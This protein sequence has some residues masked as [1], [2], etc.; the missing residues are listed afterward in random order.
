MRITLY[1]VTVVVTSALAVGAGLLVALAF[2][3]GPDWT[4]I[5]ASAAVPFFVFGPL[6]LGVVAAFWDPSS[7][8]GRSFSRWWFLGVVGVDVAAAVVVIVASTAAGTPAWVPAVLIAAGAALLAAARP[9][10]ALVRR[11]ERPLRS[12]PWDAAALGIDPATVRRKTRTVVITFV[13]AAAVATVGVVLLDTLADG[14]KDIAAS[15]LVA[16]QLAFTAAAFAGALVA[17]PYAQTLRDLGG[18][19]LGRLRRFGK[20]VLRGKD[21]PLEPDEQIAAVRYAAVAQVSMRLQTT[22]LLLLYVGI[23]C[24]FV[25]QM[26]RGSLGALPATIL[27][28]MV[29]VLAF[30]LPL[31]MQRIRRARAYVARHEDDASADPAVTVVP[32]HQGERD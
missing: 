26:L 20:V 16:G 31:T 18:R 12:G 6:A 25:S 13:V 23:A 19:D 17:T 15:A 7:R 1:L 4:V 30:T 11:T 27:V 8:D 10:G 14:R 28:L 9:V 22:F 32:G 5:A 2:R 3:S 29:V 21:L 24:Q